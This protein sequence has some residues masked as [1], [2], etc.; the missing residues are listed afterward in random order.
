MIRENPSE[1]VILGAD[2]KITQTDGIE[3]NLDGFRGGEE[4]SVTV[5]AVAK[6]G[7]TVYRSSFVSAAAEMTVPSRL[8]KPEMGT[9][10]EGAEANLTADGEETLRVSEF[11][12]GCIT[13]N[14]KKEENT[15]ATLRYQIALELYDSYGDVNSPEKRW[16]LWIRMATPYCPTKDHPET[17]TYVSADSPLL[18]YLKGL[19]DGLRREISKGCDA[20]HE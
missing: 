2:K 19:I 12:N 10:A 6:T 15:P 11:E 4:I 7:D 18:L 16:F 3:L 1:T 8:L 20:Q 17:M 9:P 14:M 5:Q 13:L